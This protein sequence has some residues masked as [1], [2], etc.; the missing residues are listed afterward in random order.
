MIE[1]FSGLTEFGAYSPDRACQG[2]LARNTEPYQAFRY[3]ATCLSRATSSRR[4]PNCLSEEAHHVDK[5]LNYKKRHHVVIERLDD[6][7]DRQ[8]VSSLEGESGPTTAEKTLPN[9]YY[10]P[11]TGFGGI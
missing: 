8:L 9:P 4:A 11:E 6:S 10:Y 7:G 2:R 5:I 3:N 1:V